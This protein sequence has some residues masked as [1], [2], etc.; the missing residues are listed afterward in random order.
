MMRGFVF[1]MGLA[2][3]SGCSSAPEEQP[4]EVAAKFLEAISNHRFEEAKRYGTPRMQQM[5]D[6]QRSVTSLGPGNNNTGCSI[7]SCTVDG[8]RA[9]VI[10]KREAKDAEVLR[11]TKNRDSWLVGQ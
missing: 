9:F 7:L 11:L 8:D 1:V 3:L 6:V 5:L 4:K 10:Y 2:I